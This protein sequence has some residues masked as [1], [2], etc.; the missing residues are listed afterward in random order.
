MIFQ[1]ECKFKLLVKIAVNVGVNVINSEG[2]TPTTSEVCQNTKSDKMIKR[3][4][5]DLLLSRQCVESNPGPSNTTIYSKNSKM[6]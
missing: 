2:V 1:K 4:I 5:I 3:A 6:N